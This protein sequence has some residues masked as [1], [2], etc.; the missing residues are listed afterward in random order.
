MVHTYHGRRQHTGN[1]SVGD[2]GGVYAAADD[3]RD[4]KSYVNVKGSAQIAGNKKGEEDNN[5]YLPRYSGGV[6]IRGDLDQTAD[7]RVTT[8]NKPGKNSPVTIAKK[9]GWVSGTVTVPDGVFKVDGADGK[10][11]VDDK[12]TVTLAPCSHSWTTYTASGAVITAKCSICSASGGSVTINKPAH[13]TYG[14]GQSEKATLTENSWQG[15]AVNENTI[16]YTKGGTPLEAAPTNAGEY[17]ASITLGDATASVVYTIAKAAPTAS[18]FTFAAPSPLTYDGNAKTATVEP[19]T[20]ING[21]GAV[22]VK[23]FKNG[24]ET[25]PKDA[26]DYTVKVSVAE[27]ANYNATTDDLTTD[28][29]KFTIGKATQTITVPTDKTIVKDGI[30]E[31]ISD[32]A[33][34]RGRDRW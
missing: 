19:N 13:T 28:G 9:S 34:R 12:G 11:S 15:L 10:I 14:D 30:A 29:W 20:G 22:T 2:G 16:T 26:G 18:D 21:M 27:G 24:A 17:T 23:Y 7:I 3:K 33:T 25:E 6:T 32:W 1:T 8:E 4:A 31:D 5:L